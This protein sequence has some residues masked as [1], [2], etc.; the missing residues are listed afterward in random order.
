[1]KPNKLAVRK[2]LGLESLDLTFDDDLFVI[3]GPNGAGKSSI[4]EALFFALYGR[5]IRSGGKNALVHRGYPQESLRTVLEFLLGGIRFRIIREYSAKRGSTAL[6]EKEESGKWIAVRSGERMVNLE[7]ERLIGLDP[8][9]FQAAVFLP[10]GETLSFVE[11]TPA[12][13]FQILSTLFGL[14]ILDDIREKVKSRLDGLEAVLKRVEEQWESLKAED[15]DEK[16][17]FFNQEMEELRKR[18]GEMVIAEEAKTITVRKLET[19]NERY[20]ELVNVR[21]R[22]SELLKT[23]EHAQEQAEIDRNIQQAIYVKA[24]F[25]LPYQTSRDH[26]CRVDQ[27]LKSMQEKRVSLQQQMA[28]TVKNIQKAGENEKSL[29]EKAARLEHYAERLD[30]DAR[31]EMNQLQLLLQQLQIAT[32]EQA[33]VQNTLL[34]LEKALLLEHEKL[35]KLRNNIVQSTG[36]C[37]LLDQKLMR[38]EKILDSY[39]PLATKK[40]LLEKEKIFHETEFKEH[41]SRSERLARDVQTLD[42]E[43]LRVEAEWEKMETDKVAIEHH[44]QEQLKQYVTSE[45]ESIW[46][47]TGT[48][49]VCGSHT[50]VPSLLESQK[51]PIDIVET[52]KEYRA[53]QN[54]WTGMNLKIEKIR[55]KKQLLLQTKTETDQK[56]QLYREKLSRLQGEEQTINESLCALV[57][58]L[59]FKEIPEYSNLKAFYE[60]ERARRDQ[61]I[62]EIHRQENDGSVLEEKIKGWEQRKQEMVATVTEL[63]HQLVLLNLQVNEKRNA[64][65]TILRSLN[66]PP[67]ADQLPEDTFQYY[68]ESCQRSLN[69]LTTQLRT[70]R[71][72]FES[73]QTRKDML[74]KNLFELE[75]EL[76]K[77]SEKRQV[78]VQEESTHE[79]AF[80]QELERL[81]WNQQKFES[82]KDRQPGGW[83]DKL[84]RWEGE[85]RQVENYI[86]NLSQQVNDLCRE[87]TVQPEVSREKYDEEKKQLEKIRTELGEDRKK[88][89]VVENELKNI[90]TKME[91]KK[92]LEREIGDIRKER[93]LHLQLKGA[94][95]TKGFKNYL[96][97]FLLKELESEASTILME[98]SEGRYALEVRMNRGN[99]EILVIDSRYG[100]Q[101]RMPGE[102]SGGEK[103]LI[104]LALALALSR[105]RLRESGVNRSADCLFIDEGFSP[106]D[107]EHL[108]LVADA[109][110]RL[111]QDG[112]MVGVVT[113]DPLFA[114]L[115]P[116][117]LEVCEGEAVWKKNQDVR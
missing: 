57:E 59:S 85:L 86:Q 93:D 79:M 63:S 24:S 87:L 113:H 50:P 102:C 38:L 2:F 60:R 20:Q 33:R 11:A 7:L 95:E 92:N 26:L 100:W 83:Q 91:E 88:I 8:D 64:V 73:L 16:H 103:T 30:N 23:I 55:E 84:N 54:S 1:M 116:I 22:K 62:Q 53:F 42:Q 77:L 82:L 101:E 115:F 99:T 19:L 58:D 90:Q 80:H 71:G 14:G 89:G 67:Q 46:K 12:E 105:I 61:L 10:Q 28:E 13:R 9:T 56:I 65:F 98:L 39:E 94:L 32:S 109:I 31:P 76:Q 66:L 21:Q 108:E 47:Q 29:T 75:G 112:R 104:A 48:C 81:G 97:A 17:R 37:H 45:L 3:V 15:L 74:E 49:P 72:A 78:L 107:R 69:T 25:W 43:L 4:L 18:I 106:L 41:Q 114:N 117:H 111:G 44:Y 5:S 34:S 96:L 36:K 51:V 35:R 27:D 6:L 68:W 110:L 40:N 70:A 52:E